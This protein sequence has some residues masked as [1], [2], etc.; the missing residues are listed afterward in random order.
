MFT[1]STTSYEDIWETM[2]LPAIPIRITIDRHGRTAAE[3]LWL[4]IE[5]LRAERRRSSR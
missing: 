1:V 3:R 2:R 4:G 5:R